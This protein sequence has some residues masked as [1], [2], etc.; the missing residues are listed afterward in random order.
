L[1]RETVESGTRKDF[2]AS[3]Y[4][5][6]AVQLVIKA[7]KVLGADVS[8]Q[9]ALYPK[10]VSKINEVFPTYHTQCEHTLA[11]YFDIT[12]NKQETAAGLAKLVTE[13]GNRLD[14]GFVGTP[15][16]LHALSDNGYTELAYTLLLQ[17]K[18]PSWLFSVKQGATTIWEHWDGIRE[19]GSV[20]SAGM[21]S[22]NHYAYGAVA[23]WVYGVAA[24][25]QTVEEAP[26]FAKAVIAP[27]PD[28]RLG[29]LKAS[30][31]TRHGKI[32]SHWYAF[33]GGWRYEIETP[34][35]TTLILDGKKIE[36]G[37][38]SYLF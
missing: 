35:D 9:E 29:W 6:H 13:N 30:L 22:Y 3:V 31:E 4:Y 23:D 10:I 2:I 17:E 38:G 33:E 37:P 20:W 32:S 26:G 18:Y 24:G 8:E 15:Y 28:K 27:H 34:V 5:A 14:T 21:N 25:I 7:G 16:L 11:L 19:D 1:G 36:I 12:K